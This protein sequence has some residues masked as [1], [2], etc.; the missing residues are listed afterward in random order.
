M[1]LSKPDPLR[2]LRLVPLAQLGQLTLSAA[3]KQVAAVN[4]AYQ[5]KQRRAR[6]TRR[7]DLLTLPVG[8]A[9]YIRERYSAS[10]Y[11]Q[12][13]GNHPLRL[14]KY[15]LFAH[16]L[17]RK[18]QD[19]YIQLDFVGLNSEVLK[20]LIGKNNTFPYTRVISDLEDWGVL[21]VDRAFFHW[22]PKSRQEVRPMADYCMSFRFAAAY[23][24]LEF[25]T[26]PMAGLKYREKS[27]RDRAQRRAEKNRQQGLEVCVVDESAAHCRW[28]EQGYRR[29]TLSSEVNSLIEQYERDNIPLKDKTVKIK[30]RKVLRTGRTFT[31]EIAACYRA[32]VTAFNQNHIQ[33][34]PEFAYSPT[35]GRL[36]TGLTRLFTDGRAFVEIDGVRTR[37]EDPDLAASQ[38]YLLLPMLHAT[39]VG[40]RFPEALKRF[41]ALV[42]GSKFYG[43]LAH[44]LEAYDP[45]L[46]VKEPKTD[47]FK[48]VVY[49]KTHAPTPYRQAF[50]HC[51]GRVN[52]ALL[53]LIQ[54]PYSVGGTDEVCMRYRNLAVDLQ[55]IEA[56]LFLTQIASRLHLTLGGDAVVL[57]LYD[58]FL[59][60][61]EHLETVHRIMVEVLFE[62]TGFTPTVRTSAE[63]HAGQKQPATPEQDA[64]QE[65]TVVQQG[66][67]LGSML[68]LAKP[69]TSAVGPASGTTLGH[70]RVPS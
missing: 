38:V 2:D 34:T 14:G 62:A 70:C 20:R 19:G 39:R 3:Q 52:E 7:P 43:Q 9:A 23:R 30:E 48:H 69:S 51:F 16:L 1:P 32:T 27:Q 49:A 65:P 67:A 68:D 53:E 18:Q 11:G 25:A 36:H 61:P 45:R 26:F 8:L 44:I 21:E 47:F 41:T 29:I 31:P 4:A 57:T 46:R 56:D 64:C 6:A 5:Q 54:Q 58:G 33:G 17:G 13:K 15:F 55:R 59:C 63:K 12:G 42:L 40:Q 37:M 22:R 28:L 50:N 60:Q 24:G 35:N 10:S 66:H